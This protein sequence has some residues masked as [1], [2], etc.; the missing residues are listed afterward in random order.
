MGN[1]FENILGAS[2][3]STNYRIYSTRQAGSVFITPTNGSMNV[4]GCF[5]TVSHVSTPTGSAQCLLYQDSGTSQTLLAT[6]VS[7]Y[8]PADAETAIN[9]R[10]T[11]FYFSAPVALS[12]NTKYRVVMAETANADAA[13]L[14]W[15]AETASVQSDA[16]TLALLPFGGTLRGT[17]CVSTCTTTANWTDDPLNLPVAALI[18]DA[19][20][21]FASTGGAGTYKAAGYIQ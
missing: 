1:V 19:S 12:P 21:P 5:L 7:Q 2:S 16:A 20:A 11:P 18:L 4:R 10:W 8:A 13:T 14:Y 9:S 15:I 6:S 17:Y 3:V